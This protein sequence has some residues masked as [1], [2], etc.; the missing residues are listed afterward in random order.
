[1]MVVLLMIG[2]VN[3]G[4]AQSEVRLV[5][6]ENEQRVDVLIGGQLFTSYIY[7]S[8]TKKPVLYPLRTAKGTVVT[9]GF[10]LESRPGERI[11]H[12]HHVGLWFTYGDVNGLDFWNNSDSIAPDK[13]NAYGTI[14][15]K[16]INKTTDGKDKGELEVTAEWVTPEGIAL[17][18][19]D[20]RF[21]FSGDAHTR[22]IER[23]TTLTA[24][25]QE[26]LFKDNKEGMLGIRVAR[27]LEHPSNK[28]ELFTD[29]SGQVTNVPSMNNEGVT[30]LY[31]SSEGKQ[32]DDVW[33]TRGKWVN[34]A[35]TMNGENISLVIMDHPKNV[36]HPTYW[37]ARGYGLFAVNNLGQKAMSN[38]KEEL[39]FKLAPGK[40]VTFRH[41]VLIHSGEQLQD[42]QIK[43]AYQKFASGR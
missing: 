35:G 14:V 16:K 37:H 10:P 7:P 28:P 38:G 18:R 40:S 6:N 19:E 34:L 27:Q 3:H 12:P 36:G 20:T 15:H 2:V 29:A 21:V 22:S 26:V 33:G 39:N 30:G 25:T 41:K 4:W 11:D 43:T 31:H 23:I 24:L 8:A 32:G 9:R 5:K 1:M 42:G 13:R 17:L